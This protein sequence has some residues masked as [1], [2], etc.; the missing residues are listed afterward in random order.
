MSCRDDAMAA[1]LRATC[2]DARSNSLSRESSLECSSMA[3]SHAS[4]GPI[5]GPRHPHTCG[6]VPDSSA[7]AFPIGGRSGLGPEAMLVRSS[8]LGQ[9]CRPFAV[10]PGDQIQPVSTPR[11]VFA[12]LALHLPLRHLVPH[13]LA[14]ADASS[15]VNL[16]RTVRSRRAVPIAQRPWVRILVSSLSFACRCD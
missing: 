11:C 2:R 10:Q 16:L 8:M 6:P 9:E 4:T 5:G 1:T 14:A 12:P 7:A 15:G 13:W 3:A